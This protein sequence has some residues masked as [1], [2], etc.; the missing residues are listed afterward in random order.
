MSIIG[1]LL[2]LVIAGV[3]L[4]LVTTYIPMAPPIKTVITVLV[5]LL[6]VV[7]LLNI[8]GLLDGT[9]LHHRVVF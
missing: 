4:W 1:I 6:L 8:F 3:C 7:W 9:M 2:V 5:V